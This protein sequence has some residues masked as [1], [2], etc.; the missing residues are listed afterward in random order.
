MSTTST[1][2][3]FSDEEIDQETERLFSKLTHVNWSRPDCELIAPLTLEINK[4]K[5]EK[6]TVILAHSYQTPDIIFGVADFSGD[7]LGLSREAAKTEADTILF[8]G[9]VFMAETAKILSPHK[10]VIVP[11]I[12][13]GCS[14]ADSITG[15]D[16]R[17]LRTK[18]PGIPIIAYVNTTADVKAE[19]DV[20]VT[21][22]NVLEIVNSIESD[23]IIFLPDKNMADY[24]RKET[25]KEVIDWEGLCI[26]HEEFNPESVIEVRDMFD[27]IY[28]IAHSECPPEVLDKVDMIGGTTDMK[29]YIEANPDQIKLFLVTECG[30]SDRFAVEYPDREFYGTCSL[31][32]YMKMNSLAN[33]LEALKNPTDEQIITLDEEL[34]NKARGSLERML[35]Y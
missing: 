23:K 19:V 33:I 16:V 29:N 4:I 12:E 25:G 32:P 27:D 6:N 28:V 24:I 8:A 2:I 30:L 22:A 5:K 3:K 35:E 11:K 21:S 20:C 9:V 13:A 1:S 10:T 14:L 34:M 17:E 15:E 31:C 7:S 26:V 18:Y